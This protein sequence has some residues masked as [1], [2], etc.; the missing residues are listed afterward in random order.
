MERGSLLRSGKKD[1][2]SLNSSFRSAE[3][4][5]SLKSAPNTRRVH[6]QEAEQQIHGSKRKSLSPKTNNPRS[7]SDNSNKPTLR[8]VKSYN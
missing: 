6:R 8:S 2:G 1:A 3:D 7:S 4:A 5:K